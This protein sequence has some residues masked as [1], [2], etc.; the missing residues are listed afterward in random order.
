M[1]DL[2]PGL[3]PR[4]SLTIVTKLSNKQWCRIIEYWWRLK[5]KHM[6]AGKAADQS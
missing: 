2:L 6:S 1:A 4:E 3:S 5:H